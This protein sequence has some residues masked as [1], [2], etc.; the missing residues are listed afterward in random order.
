MS[1]EGIPGAI[2]QTE[3]FDDPNAPWRKRLKADLEA[4]IEAGATL[5]GYRKDG[6]Y[7]ARNKQGD[8]AIPVEA[9][10]KPAA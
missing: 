9:P 8:R 2:V 1:I 7:V 6:R 10:E 4:Q 5:Y 3:P